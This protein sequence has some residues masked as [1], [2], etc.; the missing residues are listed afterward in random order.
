MGA[1]K[2]HVDIMPINEQM[3]ISRLCLLAGRLLG[4]VSGALPAQPSQGLSVIDDT[5]RTLVLA[6]PARR[7]VS[8][9]PASTAMI[10][11]AGGGAQVVGTAEFSVEPDAARRIARIGD[12]HGFDLERILKL[13][14][15]VVVA[16]SGGA[17]T[18]QLAPLERAG[19]LVYR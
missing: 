12:A 9:S 14:P 15:D 6:R 5:G 1:C 3:R 8:L 10:F 16:W 7:V 18:A 19:L 11:A 4:P 13:H 2:K 17:S